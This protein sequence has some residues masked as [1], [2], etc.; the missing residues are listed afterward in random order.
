MVRQARRPEAVA[1]P[2]AGLAALFSSRTMRVAYSIGHWAA[3]TAISTF[4]HAKWFAT[5][6]Y[7]KER[8]DRR[9]L[10]LDPDRLA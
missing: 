4:A 9:G 5:W 10:V 6:E 7:F 1:Q 3:S 2:E 8:R